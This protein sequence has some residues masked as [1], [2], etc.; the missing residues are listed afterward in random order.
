MS[1]A[2]IKSVYPNFE[3]RKVY[4]D[5]VYN[6][7]DSIRETSETVPTKDVSSKTM[8]GLP[9]PFDDEEIHFAR[10]LLGESHKPTL[11]QYKLIEGMKADIP[12]TTVHETTKQD[13]LRF[14]NIP[15]QFNNTVATKGQIE[16]FETKEQDNAKTCEVDCDAHINHVLNCPRCKGVITRQ[17]NL[18]NDRVR[19]EEFMEL[20]SYVIFGVF[21]LLLID[22][23]KKVD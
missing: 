20:F 11:P 13:N 2:Y 5:K 8:G 14:Y 6:S 21:M 19:N 1:Y 18:D 22:N 9:T 10:S 12:P 17:L 4:D 7:L 15:Y 3:T 23:L 16:T